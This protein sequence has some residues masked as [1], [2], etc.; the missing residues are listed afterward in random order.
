MDKQRKTNLSVSVLIGMLIVVLVYALYQFV[1]AYGGIRTVPYTALLSALKDGKIESATISDDDIQA[2]LKEEDETHAKVLRAIRVDPAIAQEF[3]Q[4]GVAVTGTLRG[5]PILSFV[6]WLFPILFLVMLWSNLRGLGGASGGLLAEARS[7]AKIYV[8]KDTKVL[9]KDVAGIDEAKRELEEVV[10]FLKAPKAHGRLGA[11]MPKGILLVGPPGTGK[12]LLARALAGE[13]GVPFFSIS[14]SEFVEMFVGVGAA[15]V[16]DLFSQAQKMAPCIVFID[17]LDALG[18][19]RGFGPL[20]GS[21]DEKEQTLN[22]L[23]AEMDGFDPRQ[24]VVLLAATNRPEILDPALLRAGRFDRQVLV[25]RP[26]KAGRLEILKIHVAKIKLSPNVALETIAGLTVGFTGADL[27][28]LVNEAAL[29]ATRRDADG[30]ASEDFTVAFERIVAGLEK[31]TRILNKTE[32][33]VVAFHEMGHALVSLALPGAETVHKISIVPRGLSALGYTLQRPTEDRF[34]LRQEELENRLK[35]LLGG[36]AAEVLV[37]DKKSTG[38]ADDLAKATDL[39]RAMVMQYGMD[40]NLGDVAYEPKRLQ[41]ID[42]P[43]AGMPRQ[44]SEQTAHEIDLAVQRMVDTALA[45]AEAIL[46][47][48]RDLLDRGA[49]LLMEH[50]TLQENDLMQLV[51]D[52]LVLEDAKPAR[53][54]RAVE[55]LTRAR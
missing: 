31:K 18:R 32:R 3:A 25:D 6:A 40:R 27:A 24:G 51:K 29:A 15:R 42:A 20:S 9:F 13:A 53:I 33:E 19:A 8:E 54:L 55:G 47:I 16:R 7:K 10:A 12:T 2:R 52:K 36:R 5:T 22:Q 28:N 30:V 43:F 38:A 14:G 17:E 1:P 44:Y 34:L 49:A 39:A 23:L 26:D 45:D 21:H 48:N 41:F 35:I 4:N 11:R 46:K 50:E 37:F